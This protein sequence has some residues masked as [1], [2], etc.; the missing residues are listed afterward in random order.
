MLPEYIDLS[1]GIAFRQ[2]VMNTTTRARPDTSGVVPQANSYIYTKQVGIP[3]DSSRGDPAK[4]AE[5]CKGAGY[6]PK[7]LSLNVNCSSNMDFIDR[8]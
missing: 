5:G 3:D 2:C 1:C 7:I 4:L 8:V 6:A